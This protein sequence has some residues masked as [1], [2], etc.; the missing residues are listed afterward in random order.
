MNCNGCGALC[1]RRGIRNGI[2]QYRCN[3]CCKYQRLTYQ[4]KPLNDEALVLLSQLSNEGVGIRG[5][6]RILHITASSVVRYLRMLASKIIRPLPEESDQEYEV[7]EV[8]TYV[9]K[10]ISEQRIYIM[11]AIN[12]HTRK[13]IYYLVGNRTKANL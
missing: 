7:D 10:N 2:Q 4:R 3:A 12:K 13:V 1:V 6:A 11:Y 5:I 8:Q 9:G